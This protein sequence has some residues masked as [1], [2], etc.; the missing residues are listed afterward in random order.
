MNILIYAVLSLIL[1]GGL[2]LLAWGVRDALRG[3]A[4]ADWPKTNGTVVESAA[5]EDE[6][7]YSSK[8][9]VGYKVDGREYKTTT[10]R[11]GASSGSSDP[12]DAEIAR[13]RYPKGSEVAVA[14]HP[15]NP[16]LAAI[17]PGFSAE[18]L[19]MPIIGLAITMMG[20]MFM[21][22]YRTSSA[23]G[24]EMSIV[25][26]WI[27]AAIFM[28]IG[29][30]MLTPGV[31]RIARARESVNWPKAP[32]VILF[33]QRTSSTSVHEDDEGRETTST[34]YSSPLVAEYEVNGRKHYTK[35]RRFGQL[36]GS[37]EEWAREIAERY[38]TGQKVQVAYSPADP[39]LSVLEPGITS[40]AYWLPG[41]GA[42]F[43]LFGL[44]AVLVIRF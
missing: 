25:V 17:K 30:A 13:L 15:Q 40:E 20:I 38:P 14:Y 33:S 26:V 3:A 11:F 44:I 34:T 24:K 35:T 37:G 36:A 43:F 16:A 41:A 6:T 18:A 10:T 19:T 21:L 39:D 42:A 28:L 29:H 12:S 7:S 31:R 32:G 2:Y 4:S 8:I 9:T 1:L 5:T 27:F 23:Q 22:A